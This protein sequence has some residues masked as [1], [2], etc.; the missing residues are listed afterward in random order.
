MDF[1]VFFYSVFAIWCSFSCISIFGMN[2]SRSLW[3]G[4]TRA[5]FLK[6][7]TIFWELFLTIGHQV[8]FYDKGKLQ[9]CHFASVSDIC[10]LLLNLIKKTSLKQYDKQNSF[11]RFWLL[12]FQGHV[13][14]PRRDVIVPVPFPYIYLPCNKCLAENFHILRFFRKA[15]GFALFLS[16][17]CPVERILYI[18]FEV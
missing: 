5:E 18:I 11:Y 14:A 13:L 2:S 1:F 6:E 3:K 10:F 17:C 9:I 12:L 15:Q 8:P 4:C 7:L 16:V